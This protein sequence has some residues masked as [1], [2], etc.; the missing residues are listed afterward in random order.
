M[1]PTAT[2]LDNTDDYRMELE[3]TDGILAGVKVYRVADAVSIEEARAAAGLP[4]RGAPWSAAY[5]Q[6]KAY[7]F[8]PEREPGRTWFRV[9][10]RYRQDTAEVF[11]PTDGFRATTEI[12][13]SEI[14]QQALF[15]VNGERLTPDGSGVSLMATAIGFQVAEYSDTLPSLAQPVALCTPFPKVSDGEVV[16]PNV[17]ASGVS[18]T[19]PAGQLL[20]RSFSLG[21]DGDLFV[22]RHRLLRAESW[23][24]PR[25]ETDAAGDGGPTTTEL[26]AYLAAAFPSFN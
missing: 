10:A 19:V 9:T 6:V 22:L 13:A 21:R 25:R 8:T 7:G 24:I 3:E 26:D 23:K 18:I 2:L 20:Y 14:S 12:L 17:L 4:V 16:L 15:G 5:P 11:T 1:P